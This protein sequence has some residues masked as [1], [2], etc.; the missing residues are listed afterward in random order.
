MNKFIWLECSSPEYIV[1][2]LLPAYNQQGYGGQTGYDMTGYGAGYDNQAYGYQYAEQSGYATP[3]AGA[4]Y[5]S[6][7]ATG[8]Y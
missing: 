1:T 3:A 6:Y 8:H 4:Q 5:S 7:S 2:P